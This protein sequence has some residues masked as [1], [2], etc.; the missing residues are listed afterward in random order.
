M[1]LFD[2]LSLVPAVY[3]LDLRS[4]P[5]RLRARVF[6][7]PIVYPFISSTGAWLYM[8]D[9]DEIEKALTGIFDAP[10]IAPAR[11]TEAECPSTPPTPEITAP[12]Q[13][14]PTGTPAES[15]PTASP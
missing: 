7:P 5:D 12:A 10:V 1:T 15:T 13:A 6:E 8:P 14:P 4:N 11:A 2:M 3:E 9:Y